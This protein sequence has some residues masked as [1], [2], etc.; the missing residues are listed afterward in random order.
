M[1]FLSSNFL[2]W[3]HGYKAK[4]VY[5]NLN[6][7]S[8]QNDTNDRHTKERQFKAFSNDLLRWNAFLDADMQSVWDLL[9]NIDTSVLQK[10]GEIED[11]EEMRKM[12]TNLRMNCALYLGDYT[13]YLS[14]SYETIMEFSKNIAFLEFS[15]AELAV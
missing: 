11:E 5:A 6:Y 8:T 3:Y 14:H 15:E 13:Q 10:E 9:A 2:I 4:T 1:R 12:I 7:I